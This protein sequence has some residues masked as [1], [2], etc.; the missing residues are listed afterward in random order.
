[1][2]RSDINRIIEE[3]MSFMKERG[4][5]LPPFAH[6]TPEQWR[7]AG[8]EADEIRENQLGW[9]ITNFGGDDFLK[10]GLTIFTLR[11]GNAKNPAW[12]KPYAEKVLVVE[13]GQVTPMHYHK[14]KM[15]DII[16]RGGGVL[17]MQVYNSTPDGALADTP[18]SVGTDGVLRNV[19][20]GTLL[21]L[22]PGESVTVT[23]L[24]YHKFWAEPGVGKLL[25]GEVS[26]VNDDYTDN[27]FHEPCGRFPEID[28]DEPARH[29]LLTEYPKP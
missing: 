20:A 22:G 8:A 11:N 7:R 28:E 29:L 17:V 3:A 4:F 2:K 14:S 13:E 10:L 1:M 21:R 26:S 19:P 12:P 6:W 16:N 27:F 5:E 9:D 15:E 18:V 24:L 25:L 23:P